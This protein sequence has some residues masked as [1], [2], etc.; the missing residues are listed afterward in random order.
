VEHLQAQPID[1]T[2]IVP[3]PLH[4]RRA[5]ERGYNQSEMLAI[6]LAAAFDIPVANALIR[7]RETKTQMKLPAMERK[8]NMR[9]AFKWAGNDILDERILLIDDVCTTGATLEACSVA[10]RE[11]HP[12]SVW[13]LCLARAILGHSDTHIA[14]SL[15]T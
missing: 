10:L 12:Q 7:I 4:Q 8:A 11:G 3:V 14:D 5:K 6:E 15:T 9:G 2:L 13:G 1:F